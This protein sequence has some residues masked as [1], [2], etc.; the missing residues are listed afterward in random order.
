MLSETG[1]MKSGGSGTIARRVD[2]LLRWLN[3]LASIKAV[4]G[5]YLAV[6]AAHAGVTG[7]LDA[8]SAKTK[9]IDVSRL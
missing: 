7:E 3:L 6:I 2:S 8:R 4:S 5:F 1:E 9:T